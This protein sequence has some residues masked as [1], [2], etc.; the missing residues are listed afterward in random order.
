MKKTEPPIVVEQIFNASINDIWNAVSEV[1]QMIQWFFENIPSFKPEVGFETSFIV[2]NEGR[3][4]P[5]L[6]RLT[7]VEPMKKIVYNWKYEGYSGDSFVTFELF[8]EGNQT[9]LKLT[10]EVVESFQSGIPEFTRESCIGG[11]NYFIKENL[12]KYLEKGS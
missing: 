8:E 5:H 1:D 9:K 7:E 2:E 6:W 12:K 4:F 3:I 10:H 11:W